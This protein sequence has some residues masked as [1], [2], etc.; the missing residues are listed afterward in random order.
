MAVIIE[1]YTTE[2]AQGIA[3]DA[4]RTDIGMQFTIGTTGT[5]L[6]YNLSSISF[7]SFRVG[8]PGT[9]T[10]SVY[11]TDP[12]G[13]PSGSAISTGTFDGDTETTTNSTQTPWRN[14]TMSTVTLKR[15]TKYIF[16]LSGS[17]T[18]VNNTIGMRFDNS[19]VGTTYAGGNYVTKTSGVWTDTAETAIDA[20]FI[21]FSADYAGTLCTLADAINKAGTNVNATAK[22]ESLVSDFVRQAE[23]VINATTRFDWVNAYSGLTNQVKF[24]LNQVASDLAAIYMITYDMSGFTDRVE[25]ETMINVYRE[26]VARGLS[27]LRDQEVKSFITG[28]T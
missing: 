21:I 22:N 12:D 23:G 9:I 3:T 16:A 8:S 26:A 7:Q 2:D 4:T 20:M 6:D 5:N 14:V 25:A 19:A 27:L 17:T 28:D 18:D 15:S 24:L 13:I 11:N 10:V 1:S